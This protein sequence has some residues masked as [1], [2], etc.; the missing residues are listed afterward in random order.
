MPQYAAIGYTRRLARA[1]RIHAVRAMT[2][3]KVL[4]A[5]FLLIESPDGALCLTC[6]DALAASFAVRIVRG[7]RSLIARRVPPDAMVSL[8]RAPR[9]AVAWHLGISSSEETPW[10]LFVHRP[11]GPL[12][13]I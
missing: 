12:I 2:H 10:N 7:G 6:T 1:I 3:T 5:D 8:P 11:F 9:G 4:P 13:E